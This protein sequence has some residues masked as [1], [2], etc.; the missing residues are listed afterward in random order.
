M[1]GMPVSPQNSDVEI[2]IPKA[3]VLGGGAFGKGLGHE[4]GARM[5][6]ISALIKETP[7]GVPTVV[8]W[9]KNLT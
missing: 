3:M 9:V 7:E 4:G 6:R 5:N 8:Q 2:P 1:I